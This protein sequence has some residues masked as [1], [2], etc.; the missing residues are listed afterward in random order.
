MRGLI[1]KKE[2]LELILS[3]KKTIEIRSSKTS[4]IGETIYLLESKTHLVR[5]T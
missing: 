5:G 2:W 3:G 1:I 4:C